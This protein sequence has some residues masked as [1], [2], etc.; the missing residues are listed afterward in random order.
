[1]ASILD[2]MIQPGSEV[3]SNSVESAQL[4]NA[5]DPGNSGFSN[6]VSTLA[7][8]ASTVAAFL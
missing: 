7:Q 8:V 3:R 6:T 1:M 5:P 2:S 4:Q